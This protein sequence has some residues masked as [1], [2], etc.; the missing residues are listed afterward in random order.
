MS[1][2]HNESM[3]WHQLI[4]SMI[5]SQLFYPILYY[6]IFIHDYLRESTCAV[7]IRSVFLN[8]DPMNDEPSR[9]ERFDVTFCFR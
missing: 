4:L 1:D 2:M 6:H 9:S 7:G 5:F 3:K 8:L